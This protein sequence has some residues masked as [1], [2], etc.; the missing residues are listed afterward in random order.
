MAY[1]KY[2]LTPANNNAAPPDGA[3]EGMLPSGVNDTMRDMM[4][5]I[6]DVGDGIRGGTY[7]MTAPVIT[8]GTI[9]GVAL[10]GNTFTSPVISGGSINNTPIGATTANTGAFTTLSATGNVSFD[11]GSFVFNET[12]ADKDARFEGDTDANLLFLDASTDRI[13][14]GTSSPSYKLDVNGNSKVLRLSSV[15]ADVGGTIGDTAQFVAVN[16]NAAVGDFS[17]IRFNYYNDGDGGGKFSYI[18]SVLTSTSTFGAADI[19]FG[20]RPSSTSTISERMRIDSD[21]NLLLGTTTRV[22]SFSKQSISVNGATHFGIGINDANSVNS[23]SFLVFQA[24][25]TTIGSITNNNSTGVLY[26]ITS[27]YRLKT[28]IAPV[29]NAGQRIDALQPIEYDWKVNGGRTRGFLAHQFAEVYPNSVSG[30]KDAIDREGKPKYQS[31][32]AATSEVMADL[33]AEIQSLRKR[34][35]QLE[36]K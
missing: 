30:E 36:S 5:Q 31:M 3:P 15:T 32:Q 24:G 20:T 4:A 25:G 33:I 26:N 14:I 8:G 22:G 34:V 16:T 13:G 23:A 19:V 6:R 7:T 21:G 11:G 12:G 9:T 28:V 29:T 10:T 1:T 27:D 17:G 2:S 18:G 35:A